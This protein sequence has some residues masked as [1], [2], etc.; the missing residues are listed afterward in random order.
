MSLQKNGENDSLNIFVRLLFLIPIRKEIPLLKLGGKGI[1]LRH[2]T[3][4]PFAE[5]NRKTDRISYQEIQKI[6]R[7]MKEWI[8]R[9][10]DFYCIIQ[11]FLAKIKVKRFSWHTELG[12]ED[13]ALTAILVGLL[14]NLKG[15]TLMGLGHF[16]ILTESP[17]IRVIPHYAGERFR[18][19]LDLTLR[20]SLGQAIKTAILLIWNLRK[21]REKSW[22]SILFRA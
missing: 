12:T 16:M 4:S 10:R 5:G 9:I 6:R 21:G 22:K 20:F 3:D 1:T 17:E 11:G 14:W 2:E 19:Y 7:G 8:D 15:V 18:T 13:A